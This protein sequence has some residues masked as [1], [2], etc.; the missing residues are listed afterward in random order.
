MSSKKPLSQ[1]QHL[2][3]LQVE[4]RALVTCSYHPTA[5]SNPMDPAFLIWKHGPTLAWAIGRYVEDLERDV[6]IALRR[7]ERKIAM[8]VG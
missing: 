2:Q 6:P 4:I 3:R 7:P 1:L 8:E 5:A